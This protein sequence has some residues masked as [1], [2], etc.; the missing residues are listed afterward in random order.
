MRPEDVKTFE[1]AVA[2]I[3]GEGRYRVFADIMRSRGRYPH[4]RLRL[5]ELVELGIT[6]VELM[7]VAE[8]PGARGW[9]YDGVLPFAPEASYGTPE[10]LKALVNAA[11][12]LGLMVLLDVV[13][14]H[15]GPEGNYLHVYCPAFFNPAHPTPWG[16]AINFDGEGAAAFGAADVAAPVRAH[17]E[18]GPI[19]RVEPGSL[20]SAEALQVERERVADL[21]E[22]RGLDPRAPR[23]R[24]DREAG[25]ALGRGVPRRSTDQ[26][27]PDARLVASASDLG[28]KALRH[29]SVRR[30]V[31]TP[32]TG[33]FE[34]QP[35]TDGGCRAG[36]RLVACLAHVRAA[37]D[38]RQHAFSGA[39]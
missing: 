8:F 13:Y 19:V 9:G 17:E 6:A 7:P 25:H 11:H 22:R 24:A 16:A 39:A 12:E 18:E 32:R 2:Q 34:Q 20:A 10:S 36:E 28:A 15:F 37:L 1:E 27:W 3:K 33:V 14:N 23:T 21:A 26:Q 30:R 35:R 4:A 5:P 38:A 29:P 31:V